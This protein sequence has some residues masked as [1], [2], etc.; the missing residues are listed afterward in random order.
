MKIGNLTIPG[1]VVA[2][3]AVFSGCVERRVVYVE[4]PPPAAAQ[5]G[6]V[7][8]EAPP[9][10]QAEV[11]V[12]APGP[13]YIWMPGYWSWQGHW[14]WVSGAYVVRPYAHAHWV[15]GHWVHHGYGWVWVGGYWR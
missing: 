14:V 2:A 10:P 13:N 9:P 3:L 5:A 7:I 8:S 4:S 1:L 12:A 15:R 6:R 11:V